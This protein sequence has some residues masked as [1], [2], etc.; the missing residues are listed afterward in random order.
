MIT[1]QMATA[2]TITIIDALSSAILPD[3]ERR[4]AL[5]RRQRFQDGCGN[6]N[7]L[8]RGALAALLNNP[9]CGQNAS[10]SR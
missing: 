8:A 7:E 6:A 1:A 5:H 9:T 4:D 2:D 10:C 3:S